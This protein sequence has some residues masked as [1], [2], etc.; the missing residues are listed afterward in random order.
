MK[1]IDNPNVN[2]NRRYLYNKDFYFREEF[3]II[4]NWINEGTKVI[5]L[6]CGNGALMKFILD[7]KNVDIEGIESSVSGIEVCKSFG[8]K[9]FRGEIDKIEIYS[10]YLD[11]QFDYAVCNVTLQMVMYP[12]VLLKEMTRIAKYLIISFPNFAYIGNR[13]DLLLRGRMP[14]P[15]LHGYSWYNT[16]HIHQL[17]FNDFIIYCRDNGITIINQKN[18]GCFGKIA[19]VLLPNILSKATIF[20]C[21]SK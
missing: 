1:F 4:N 20:L 10:E 21:K 9:A 13:F 2:D 19:D 8:L 15:M 12:E 14:R 16:G 3:S 5:D 17:S 11:K 18:L 6:G 7:R